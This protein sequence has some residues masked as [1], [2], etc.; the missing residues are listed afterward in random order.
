MPAP[1]FS[2][3]LVVGVLA[4]LA[5]I[6]LGFLVPVGAGWPHLLLGLGLVLLVRRVVVGREGW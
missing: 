5:W 4:L 6:L 2:V 3:S 1:R